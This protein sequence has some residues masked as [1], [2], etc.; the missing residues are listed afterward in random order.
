MYVGIGCSNMFS[1]IT[2]DSSKVKNKTSDLNFQ[3][4][5]FLIKAN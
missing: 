2:V 4:F 3:N 1:M 5:T